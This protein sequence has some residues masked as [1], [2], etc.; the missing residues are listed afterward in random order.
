ML[1]VC[2]KNGS[3][4]TGIERRK[5]KVVGGGKKKDR[6]TFI[7]S[8]GK[9]VAHSP[10]LAGRGGPRKEGLSVLIGKK[11]LGRKQGAGIHGERR[12]EGEKS[13]S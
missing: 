3:E 5:K 10:G 7:F 1:G 2:C 11:E 13:E 6:T 12:T 8:R 9:K 4:E